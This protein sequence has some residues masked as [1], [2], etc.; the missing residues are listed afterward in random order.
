M[1]SSIQ[2]FRERARKIVTLPSGLEV[3]IRKIWLIDFLGSGELPLPPSGEN[4]EIPPL[5]PR[6][7]ISI[8]K[9][10]DA[11]FDRV[12]VAGCLE[13]KFTIDLETIG[14]SA[15]HVHELSRDDYEVL[16]M[17]ILSWSGSTKEVK[18]EAD[19][20]R[21]NAIGENGTGDGGEIRAAAD[22]DNASRT[23]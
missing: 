3:Q 22:R 17:E 9:E 14:D 13:P 4:P 5:N 23:R 10:N 12:I 2:E 20:F 11:Y 6:S 19:T 1:I 8:V 21:A 15:L 7:K 16:G 18:A